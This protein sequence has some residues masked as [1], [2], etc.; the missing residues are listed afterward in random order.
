[1]KE[2]SFLSLNGI[3]NGDIPA[4]AITGFGFH[5]QR[6]RPVA[7]VKHVINLGLR[8]NPPPVGTP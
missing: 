2:R 4:T 7:L 1:M 8:P 3:V 6:K 5:L